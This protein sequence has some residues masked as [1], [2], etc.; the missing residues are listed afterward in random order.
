[1]PV[2]GGPTSKH[3]ARNPAAE[4][5]K[6]LRIAQKLDDL[7][8]IFLG[9][10]D[11]GD[12]LERDAAMRLRQQFRLGLAE[13]H[14]LPAGPLHL[15]GQED[16]DAEE[17]EQR[18]AVDEKRHEPAVAVRRRL[19]RDRH[20]LLVERLHQR[21]IVRRIGREGTVIGKMTVDLIAGDRHFPNM[22]LIDLVQELAE[23]D[24]LRRRPL[25]RVLEQ[26]DQRNDKQEYDHPKCKIPEIRIHLRP[27]TGDVLEADRPLDKGHLNL[28]CMVKAM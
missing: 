24:V 16:P 8:Q 13:A 9:L 25:S 11:A 1:M 4:P 27:A 15:P 3:A 23:G 20:V 7:L 17:G 18:Q 12:I 6:L 26:H 19:G 5:L 2:P 14:G 22:A 10:V 28:R 21:R